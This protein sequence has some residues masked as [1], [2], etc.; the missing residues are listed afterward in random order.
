VRVLVQEGPALRLRYGFQLSEEWR[1]D[2]PLNGREISP[3]VS[4]DAT[5]RSLFGRAITIG[6]AGVYRRRERQTRVFASAPR[7]FGLGLE[8]LIS[9][10]L[11]NTQI[12]GDLPLVRDLAGVSWEQRMRLAD[13]LE[14]SYSYRFERNHTFDPNAPEDPLF[15]VLDITANVARLVGTAAFDSRDD[16]FDARRGTFASA[17]L[18]YAPEALGSTSGIRFVRSLTQLYHFRLW[19]GMVLASG[20]RL[21]L[22]RGLGGVDL[23]PSERFRTGGSR[24]VRGVEEGS[25]G[26]RDEIFGDVIGGN[27]MLVFNQELRFPIYR[28]LRG[29]AFLDAGNVFATPRAVSLGK[30]AG[31]SGAGLRLTTPF[32]LLRVDY[33]RLWSPAVGQAAGR[34]SF[35]IGQIF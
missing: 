22:A 11:S 15:P 19:Q 5:R 7:L 25:L 16:L 30:L 34:W 29:A 13:R 8:S 28:W 12:A 9:F 31:S 24:S 23:I 1:D 27:A 10:Q 17:S 21:G 32:G 3:G 2:D 4:A 14:L 33:G 6:A 20:A 18:E 35:G 26:P